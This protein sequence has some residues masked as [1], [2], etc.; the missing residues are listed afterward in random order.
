V[1]SA[2]WQLSATTFCLSCGAS[3]RLQSPLIEFL[4]TSVEGFNCSLHSSMI[5]HSLLSATVGV[6]QAQSH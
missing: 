1:P 5:P 6:G 3:A 2:Y 4:V